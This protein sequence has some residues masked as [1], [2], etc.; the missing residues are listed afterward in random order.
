MST[1]K[2]TVG[3][4]EIVRGMRPCRHIWLRSVTEGTLNAEHKPL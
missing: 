3:S 1:Q 4:A 2:S